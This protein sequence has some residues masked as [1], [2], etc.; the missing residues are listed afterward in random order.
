MTLCVHHLNT[1]RTS[2]AFTVK[3]YIF[4]CYAF[5]PGIQKKEM[6]FFFG[7]GGNDLKNMREGD[8]KGEEEE[9]KKIKPENRKTS[10]A[11][12][13]EQILVLD[14]KTQYF[15]KPGGRCLKTVVPKRVY[16]PLLNCEVPLRC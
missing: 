11:Y 9:R 4:K 12:V 16:L 1:T 10:N 2:K 3:D 14:T 8:W 6:W 5:V 15:W 7:G 13:I